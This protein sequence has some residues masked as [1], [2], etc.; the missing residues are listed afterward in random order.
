MILGYSEV[1]TE[2]QS[3]DVQRAVGIVRLEE[4]MWVRTEDGRRGSHSQGG[5]RET[6]GG[7]APWKKR[8]AGAQRQNLSEGVSSG[9]EEE[10]RGRSGSSQGGTK[11]GQ[12]RDGSRSVPA[13]ETGGYLKCQ[14]TIYSSCRGPYGESPSRV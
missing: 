7:G 1:L 14:A 10:D 4:G 12:G 6:K 5:N 2:H 3:A 8:R 13:D 11:L 9:W